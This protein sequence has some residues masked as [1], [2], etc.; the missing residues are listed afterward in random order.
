MPAVKSLI[1][2]KTTG[3][4]ELLLRSDLMQSPISVEAEQ[5]GTV[6]VKYTCTCPAFGSTEIFC[7]LHRQEKANQQIRRRV[8]TLRAR[9]FS[10]SRV[11]GCSGSK[12]SLIK[13]KT[14]KNFIRHTNETWK[15]HFA[16][17]RGCQSHL[18]HCRPPDPAERQ[19]AGWRLYRKRR[20]FHFDLK[21]PFLC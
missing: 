7:Y 5:W 3:R 2:Y 8:V 20:G 17:P 21:N 10:A 15:L 16:I 6:G 19:L 14:L 13:S 18:A 9:T 11:R 4:A 1:F 12:M